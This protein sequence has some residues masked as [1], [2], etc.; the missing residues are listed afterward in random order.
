[1]GVAV[2][3]VVLLLVLNLMGLISV[4]FLPGGGASSSSASGNPTA[5]TYHQAE[6]IASQTASQRGGS[7]AVAYAEAFQTPTAFNPDSEAPCDVWTYS[8]SAP[9]LVGSGS[10]YSWGFEFESLPLTG[11]PKGLFILVSNDTGTVNTQVNVFNFCPG[12][13]FPT[14]GPLPQSVSGSVAATQAAGTRGGTSFLSAHPQSGTVLMLGGISVNGSAWVTAWVM[15]YLGA[16]T[17]GTSSLLILE[18]NATTLSLLGTIAT[19]ATCGAGSIG[20]SQV[21]FGKLGSSSSQGTLYYTNLTIA[22]TNNLNTTGL[23]LAIL[24][25]NRT[26]VYPGQMPLGCYLGSLTGCGGAPTSGG[27][28]AMIVSGGAVMAAYPNTAASVSWNTY[29]GSPVGISGAETLVIVSTFPL[30]GSGDTMVAFSWTDSVSG[31]VVL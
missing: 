4:P 21:T 18:L 8:P 22:A 11:I 24:E 13:D 25:P 10:A 20:S 23:G 19:T 30:S 6:G 17:S 2:V 14:R 29:S 28:Y 12:I 16:C 27:W 7:W 15:E 5:L 3:I 1:V 26:L 9:S 31:S